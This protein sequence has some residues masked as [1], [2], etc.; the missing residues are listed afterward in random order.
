MKACLEYGSGSIV[1][2]FLK[3]L[4]AQNGGSGVMPWLSPNLQMESKIA[5]L[6]FH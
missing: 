5:I 4:W 3:T 6:N 2:K 1:K